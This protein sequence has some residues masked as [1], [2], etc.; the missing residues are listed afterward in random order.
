MFGSLRLQINCLPVKDSLAGQKFSLVRKMSGLQMARE[1]MSRRRDDC[2]NPA[3]L[4]GEILYAW[5]Y[6][7]VFALYTDLKV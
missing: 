4:L 1:T 3:K 2:T 6:T 7:V 5:T